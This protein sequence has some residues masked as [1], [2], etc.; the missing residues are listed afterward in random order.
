MLGRRVRAQPDCDGIHEQQ[1]S[2][3]RRR[4]DA[5]CC[6]SVV[7]A[8]GRRCFLLAPRLPLLLSIFL[9]VYLKVRP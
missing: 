4:E 2:V 8:D 5:R 3:Q 9:F 7:P 1:L 6:P